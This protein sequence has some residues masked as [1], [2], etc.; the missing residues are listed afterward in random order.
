MVYTEVTVYT[1]MLRETHNTHKYDGRYESNAYYS[2]SETIKQLWGTRWC[3][4][5]R[6]CATSRKVE[7]SIP[8]GV[9]GSCH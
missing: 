3:R 8:D 7:G 9:T 6:H 5:L 1:C 4:C 2:F